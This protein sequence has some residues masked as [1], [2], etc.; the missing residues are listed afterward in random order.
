MS[1]RTSDAETPP[2]RP[3]AGADAGSPT[4]ETVSLRPLRPEHAARLA[5]LERRNREE[6]LV[7]APLREE[8]WFTEAAQR[9]AIAQALEAA[10]AGL[11]MPFVITLGEGERQR[12]VGRLSIT[13]IVRGAFQSASLGYWVDREEWGRG[14]ATRAVRTAVGVAF[15][16]LRLHRLQAEVQVGNEASVRVLERCGF[17]EYGRAPQYLRLGGAW[18]D[19]RLFQLVHAHWQ[20]AEGNA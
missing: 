16:G 13:A 1:P 4:E 15:G 2:R 19:C 14:V 3:D 6:L 17:A 20:E 8:S 5:E 18:R 12:V 10:E 9:A 11:G 7:G